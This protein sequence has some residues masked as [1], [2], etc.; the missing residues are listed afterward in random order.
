MQAL[1]ERSGTCRGWTFAVLFCVGAC[2]A[3]SGI[4]YTAQLT[5]PSTSVAADGNAAAELTLQVTHASREGI[6]ALDVTFLCDPNDAAVTADLRTDANGLAHASVRRTLAGN[7]V[8]TAALDQGKVQWA[9]GP[10]VTVVFA[11]SAPSLQLTA[12][13]TA[14]LV[15]D[16]NQV[17]SFAVVAQPATAG[18]QITLTSDDDQDAFVQNPLALGADGHGTVALRSTRAGARTLHA[19]SLQRPTLTADVNFVLAAGA[20]DLTRSALVLGRASF[21]GDGTQQVPVTVSLRDA[22]NNPVPNSPVALTSTV[23]GATFYPQSGTT[24]ADG[25]FAAV[26]RAQ[27]AAEVD[28]GVVLGFGQ[29]AGNANASAALRGHVTYVP[30]PPAAATSRLWA[31]PTAPVADGL[32]APTYYVAVRDAN[33][34]VTAVTTGQ[35]AEAGP[36]AQA[37]NVALSLGANG[38]A[39]VVGSPSVA[40]GTRVLTATVGNLT[41]AANVTFVAGP[42]T[43]ATSTLSCTDCTAVADG[44][45]TV[46]LL[47]CARDAQNHP[48]VGQNVTFASAG[49]NVVLAPASAAADAGGCAQVSVR[50]ATVQNTVVSL[51]QGANVL[52]NANVA[53]AL[54]PPDANTSHF[55]VASGQTPVADFTDV[56]L[57]GQLTDALSRPVAGHAVHLTAVESVAQI[58]PAQVTS[59]ANG[60]FVATLRT[61]RAQTNAVLA[62]LGTGAVL[63][64]N[65]A[66]AAVAGACP[67][68]VTLPVAPAPLFG[69]P[70][71]GSGRQVRAAYVDADSY[72]DVVATVANP[73]HNNLYVLSGGPNGL[74]PQASFL[75]DVP[76]T[77]LGLALGDFDGDGRP[78]FAA[79]N[80]AN[81]LVVSSPSLPTQ[82]YDMPY[83]NHALCVG[84]TTGDGKPDIVV[85]PA[86]PNAG[87]LILL[88][89]GGGSFAAPVYAS[90]ASS[91]ISSCV[92]VDV[93]NDG[94]GDVVLTEAN[95]STL[96][97]FS[98]AGDGSIGFYSSDAVA[99]CANFTNLVA[100]DFDRDGHLDVAATCS[101]AQTSTADNRVMAWHNDGA[102]TLARATGGPAGYTVSS[103][104]VAD[105]TGDGNADLVGG[106]PMGYAY[107]LVGDGNCG[108]AAP[109]AVGLGSVPA[110]VTA[111][112]FY[113]RSRQELAF[114]GDFPAIG[115]VQSTGVNQF[116]GVATSPL[117]GDPVS[118]S[119]THRLIATD[120]DGDGRTDFVRTQWNLYPRV[121]L[122]QPDGSFVAHV[123][124]ATQTARAVCTADFFGDG[125]QA[126]L[127]GGFYDGALCLYPNDGSG[128]PQNC[129]QVA[130]LGARFYELAAG[131]I[132]GDGLPD[133][134][135]A[136]EQSQLLVSF[137]NQGNGNFVQGPPIDGSPAVTATPQTTALHLADLSHTGRLDL[138]VGTQG[139]VYIYRNAGGGN[140]TLAQTLAAPQGL[141]YPGPNDAALAD[142]DGDGYL[143]VVT[144]SNNF[145]PWIFRNLGDGTFVAVNDPTTAA[146]DPRWGSPALLDV[147]GDGYA[148][149]VTGVVGTT[150]AGLA[151][152]LGGPGLQ[153]GP[154]RTYPM[155]FAAQLAG[156]HGT[157]EPNVRFAAANPSQQIVNFLAPTGCAP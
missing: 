129:N 54:G 51:V 85:I 89:Q 80:D 122:Q 45:A 59:D 114:A 150:Q 34:A 155:D 124:S 144:A 106:S 75:A 131:D 27:A 100:A 20:V 44:N 49:Q 142:L 6:G 50:A 19:Q 115:T 56:A 23:A 42:A 10:N 98:S 2:G 62:R 136:V 61:R 71:P 14:A 43:A 52:A 134:V 152:R 137:L 74:T 66:V 135:A 55:A 15:A 128:V 72:A 120:L 17:V 46:T 68:A 18:E 8:C 145:A 138:V 40:V 36:G 57:K 16:G 88:N 127:A 81:Q 11:D 33:G 123:G 22:R 143:D 26:L 79:I 108:F 78:D 157:T 63:K 76:G 87:V 104:Q 38:N 147:N 4:T 91:L 60:A 64:A 126:L 3:P 29:V 112:D 73:D 30:G 13:S 141:V 77:P 146:S 130:S 48:C 65:V 53:F 28:V 9:V 83:P 35:L 32:A 151:I 1:F 47:A 117:L 7:V 102:G 113:A 133:V 24:G 140:F 12:V 86:Q 110:D 31:V 103:L 92:V 96:Y 82:I 101:T 109:S 118:A 93:N 116:V 41:L 149:L 90:G 69:A 67:N 94:K 25:N 37:Q 148:D 58:S 5:G 70:S 107:T 105:V 121:Y 95:T 153:F 21:A 97:V 139:A 119:E 84:D 125:H 111:G 99:D 39:F 156:G 154:V 132:D